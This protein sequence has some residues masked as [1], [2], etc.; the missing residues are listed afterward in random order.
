MTPLREQCLDEVIRCVK[1]YRAASPPF[2]PFWR[3]LAMYE[4]A[5]FKRWFLVPERRAFEAAVQAS[6]SRKRAA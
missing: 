3:G 4:I 6:H 2:R 5:R 1:E